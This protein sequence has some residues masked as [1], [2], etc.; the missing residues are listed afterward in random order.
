MTAMSKAKEVDEAVIV[1]PDGAKL[2]VYF[3]DDEQCF[4]VLADTV[5]TRLMVQPVTHGSINIILN[6]R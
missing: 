3:D 4:K 1:A 2:R 5:G 6:K